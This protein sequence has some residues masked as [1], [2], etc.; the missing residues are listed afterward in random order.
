[1]SSALRRFLYG[2]FMNQRW[3]IGTA[4]GNVGP[5]VRWI[6]KGRLLKPLRGGDFLADPFVVP[7]TQGRVLLCELLETVRGRGVIA[8]VELDEEGEIA[9]I[10][11]IIDWAPI[12]L[13]YP[14]VLQHGGKLYCAPES[15]H[16]R[17]VR[18][19]ELT[20][21][22][23]E[24]VRFDVLFDGFA[25]VDS[26]I[27]EHE[28]HWWLL[29]TNARDGGSNSQLHAFY[30]PTLRGP[31]TPHASNPIV[32]DLSR[33][34]P[35]GRVVKFEGRL[36]RPA[37]DCTR[38]YGGGLRFMEIETLNPFEFREKE[39]WTIQAPIGRRGRHGVHTVNSAD[40]F[41]VYDAYT[42][43]FTP[44]AWLYRLREHRGARGS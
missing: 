43:R 26:T 2:A 20:S 22:A 13:S 25:C 23:R 36:Y 41:T 3:T 31:W 12:H 14:Y 21:D 28:R 42:E 10:R 11:T 18:L 38:R 29:C 15:C 6:E 40:G 9:D 32:A 4:P 44:L 37:Q 19:Y 17:T 1:M 39:V 7:G 24:V 5:D 16:A 27:F 30:A 35:A 33:A 34:R 8:R